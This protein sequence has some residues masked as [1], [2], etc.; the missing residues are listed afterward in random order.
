MDLRERYLV[1]EVE[2]SP[3]YE[4][5][6]GVVELLERLTREGRLVGLITGNTE[7]AAETKL[8]RADL[9]RFFSFGGY[10]SDAMERVDVCRTALDRAEAAAGGEFDRDGSIATGDTPRDIEAG[11]G[12]GIRVVGVA[13]GEYSVEQLRE[14]G[15]DWVVADLTAAELPF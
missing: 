1:E 7:P 2:S 15:G 10:G 14:A 13:T 6:P 8:A 9:N 5:K 3:G 11:H 12:A 4:V